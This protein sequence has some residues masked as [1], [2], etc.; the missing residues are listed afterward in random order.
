[1]KSAS[2]PEVISLWPDKAPGTEDWSEPE[3]V[4]LLPRGNLKFVR[5]VTQ[6]TL[7]AFL[8]DPSVA[9]GTAVVVCPG[10]GFQFYPPIENAGTED[11]RWLNARGVAAFVLKYRLIQTGSEEDFLQLIR[12]MFAPPSFLEQTLGKEKIAEQKE[13][14]WKQR[15]AHAP[16][17]VMDGK[18]ALRVV[19][20]RAATWGIDPQ[21]IGISGNSA[22]G[23]VAIG[24]ATEYEVD[25]RPNF[26]AS[27]SS[28]GGIW[29]DTA[30]DL[31]GE[32]ERVVPADAPPLFIAFATDDPFIPDGNMPVYS[33]WKAA[34]R[35]VE[36][37][38]YSKGGHDWNMLQQDLPIKHWIERFGEWLQVEG[39]LKSPPLV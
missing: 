37:H 15:R 18:Q 14:M 8:P 33:A 23:V 16:L 28:H 36:L 12:L 35:Q 39:F 4:T 13:K 20:E 9:N 30:P 6:P 24:T 31:R 21:R 10:G 34:G 26:V 29:P 27:I 38:S 7:T 5:N 11:T 3:Q 22:G 19:R 25:C 32:R 2:Q 17:A 1:M